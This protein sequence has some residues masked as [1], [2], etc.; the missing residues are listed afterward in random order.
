[1]SAVAALPTLA[2]VQ[3][4]DTAYLRDAAGYWTHT[5][6]RW[7]RVF[8]DVHEHISA[9]TWKGHAAGAA[10]EASYN[11][12][13]EVRAASFH[14]Q[15][16]AAVARRGEA[17]LRACR[18]AVLEAIAEARS[19]GFAVGDDYSVTDRSRGGSAEYRTERQAQAQVHAGFIRHRV[20]AL[21]AAD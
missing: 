3:S 13:V 11:D 17:Q 16:A 18:E 15:D 6:S 9:P 2:E 4:L 21:A 8:T 7:E 12:L 19:D 20:A 14:L 5:A 1:M 10:A